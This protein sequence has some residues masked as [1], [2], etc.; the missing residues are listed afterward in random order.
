MIGKL[1]KGNGR[2]GGDRIGLLIAAMLASALS[3][4]CGDA[5]PTA[6][7][8]TKVAVYGRNQAN[9]EVEFI[10]LPAGDSFSPGG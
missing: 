8:T 9:L 7:P 2:T 10:V 6:V 5:G 4:G 3:A 1:A